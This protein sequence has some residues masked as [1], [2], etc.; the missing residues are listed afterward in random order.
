MILEMAIGYKAV[1]G[2]L[3]CVDASDR[4]RKKE[5]TEHCSGLQ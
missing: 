2:F 3:N 5:A 4:Q 1:S